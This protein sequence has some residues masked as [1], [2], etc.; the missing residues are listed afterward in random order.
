VPY[1][2]KGLGGSAKAGCANQSPA[3]NAAEVR[4]ARD[5]QAALMMRMIRLLRDVRGC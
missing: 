2:V 1:G 4:A 3:K 5:R